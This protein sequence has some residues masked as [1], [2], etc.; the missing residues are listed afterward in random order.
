MVAMRAAKTDTHTVSPK[1]QRKEKLG[2]ASLPLPPLLEGQRHRSNSDDARPTGT[3]SPDFFKP[4]PTTLGL[5][6]F[7]SPA[8][9]MA[10]LMGACGDA[11][12]ARNVWQTTCTFLR[13]TLDQILTGIGLTTWCRYIR[14]RLAQDLGLDAPEFDVEKVD[15]DTCAKTGNVV[16]RA[17]L[18]L[19]RKAKGPFPVIIMRT[20]YGR[21]S[22][23]G[24]TLLAERGFAVLVQDTRGRFGSGG[25]FVPIQD[26]REDGAAT[27]AWVLQQSWCNGRLGVMGLSYL[28]FTAWAGLGAAS[29]DITAG[30]IAISQSQVKRAVLQKNGAISFELCLLWLYQVVNLL[31]GGSGFEF[32]RRLLVGA[33]RQ[34]LQKGMLHLPICELDELCLGKQLP[35]WQDGVCS[36]GNPSSN[37]WDNKDVLCDVTEVGPPLRLL[38]GWHDVFLEQ[39][40]EDFQKA[41]RRASLIVLPCSHW[42][43]FSYEHLMYKVQLELFQEQ[44][45]DKLVGDPTRPMP[46]VQLGIFDSDTIIGF[47]DWPP[48]STAKSFYLAEG[49]RLSSIP[50]MKAWR[51]SYTYDP[52]DPTPANGG[53]SFDMGNTGDKDQA[54]IEARQDVLVFTSEPLIEPVLIAGKVE[55]E[56][57]VEVGSVSADFVV[58]LCAVSATGVSMN[59]CEGLTRV[60]GPGRCRVHVDLGSCC[61]LFQRGCCIRLHVCSGAHPRWMRNLQTGE[62]V[63]TAVRMVAAEHLVLSGSR[64]TLPTVPA[65]MLEVKHES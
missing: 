41:G 42:G 39:N 2:L 51:R 38:S 21:H 61:A 8:L 7:T 35:L 11:V 29:S 55:A 56:L 46:R 44:L 27:V 54:S 28:G 34:T 62:P 45:Q 36:F 4:L 22:E 58:R 6:S 12:T 59:R 26:E 50:V 37:F 19:P 1:A 57:E 15:V 20:P 9:Q 13:V 32:F 16:L 33:W 14:N 49:G 18:H 5:A 31:G 43:I 10:G 47:D 24:Q 53:Q 52:A 65:S 60:T 63:A 64:M 40:L 17:T 48:P 23:M 25:D 30:F 3:L